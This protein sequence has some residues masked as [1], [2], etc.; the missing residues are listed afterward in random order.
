M[1]ATDPVRRPFVAALLAA[2]V[3]AWFVSGGFGKEILAEIAIFAILAMSLNLLVGT[4]GMVSLGHAA[5]FAIGAY[6]TA[7]LVVGAGWALGLA[8][9]AAVAISAI[10]AA[11]TGVFMVRLRGVF[12]IIV[13][14]AVGQM[15]H[16]FF[17]K[18]RAFGGSDGMAGT[19][20]LL[21][22]PLGI[23]L[24]DA[25]MFA[26]FAMA[27]TL[28]V[29][30]ALEVVTASPFGHTL[31]GIRENEQRMRA[32]GCRVTAHKLAAFVLAGALAGL[33]GSLAAQHTGFV[34]PELAF[35]TVSGEVLVM[36]II[37]GQGRLAG[38]IAG[39]AVV[40]LLR[41]E[42]SSR[43]EYWTFFM[44]LFFIAVALFA[45]G[46]LYGAAARAWAWRPAR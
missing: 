45:R 21:F 27:A 9:P 35:W 37:G 8:M 39:A 2:G 32:L 30:L 20:R 42:L 43:T 12:F 28:L 11:L 13:T 36:V 26:L 29:Y 33:A 7:G 34:S 19:P 1:A 22:E 6:A 10:V 41:H 24:A 23:D 14:L 18:N 16:A 5:F 40:I 17:F 44:G 3:L 4:T 46:G 38:A 15:A 31:V 25:G